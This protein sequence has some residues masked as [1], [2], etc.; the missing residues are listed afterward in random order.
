MQLLA[1]LGYEGGSHLGLGFID[2]EV[3]ILNSFSNTLQIP[4]IG[5][6]DISF[7]EQYL[8][9]SIPEN[10]CFYF[11]HSY[12]MKIHEFEGVDVAYTDYGEQVVAYVQKGNIYGAQF[13]PEKSQEA[14][15]QFLCNFLELC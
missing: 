6:N 14:G 7:K 5:W 12:A 1:K 11:V 3:R 15:L 10:S 8:F 9:K 13:H 2:A 4:H